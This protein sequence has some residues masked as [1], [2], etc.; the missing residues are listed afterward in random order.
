[1][2]SNIK[3]DN[4]TAPNSK[5]MFP[6][7]SYPSKQIQNEQQLNTRKQEFFNFVICF[8]K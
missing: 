8:N 1:M 4:I 7:V 6:I 5:D 2:D 3:G